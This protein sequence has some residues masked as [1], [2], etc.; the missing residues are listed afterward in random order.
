MNLGEK[1]KKIREK[2]NLTQKELAKKLGLKDATIVSKIENST[3]KIQADELASLYGVLGCTPDELFGDEDFPRIEI[4][5]AFTRYIN[6]SDDND[7]ALKDEILGRLARQAKNLIKFEDFLRIDNR[8]YLPTINDSL[9]T[10]DKDRNSQTEILANSVRKAWELG[11]DPVNN[12]EYILET[13]SI[14]WM[15]W[16]NLGEYSGICAPYKTRPF[17]ILNANEAR[18]RQKFSLAHE[19]CHALMD[20][21]QG[22]IFTRKSEGVGGFSEYSHIEKR[23]NFFAGKFLMALDAALE[24]AHINRFELSNP[25][26]ANVMQLASFFGMS[27]DAILITLIHYGKI[28]W[29][30]RDALKQKI[31]PLSETS[32]QTFLKDWD[33]SDSVATEFSTIPRLVRLG[34]Q[35]CLRRTINEGAL[36][37]LLGIPRQR[38]A[39]KIREY[40]SLVGD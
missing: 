5:H 34:F 6:R 39:E 22:A 26:A 2:K 14:I 7:K 15:R 1:I 16:N 11:R 30:L 10:S 12:L 20:I 4:N 35:A 32:G 31:H 28:S 8:H 37:E 9:P 36:S 24:F 29:E 3:R 40:S 19:L 33:W 38:M 27:G 13:K 21:G 23:A 25:S 18:A 17:I